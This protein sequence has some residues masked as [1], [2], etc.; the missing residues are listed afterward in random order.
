MDADKS[1]IFYSIFAKPWNVLY[2][3]NIAMIL[4]LYLE[5]E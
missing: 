5:D 3:E 2:I 4:M 1:M